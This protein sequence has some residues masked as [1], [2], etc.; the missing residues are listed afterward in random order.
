[1]SVP[2]SKYCGTCGGH[3]GHDLKAEAEHVCPNSGDEPEW[4]HDCGAELMETGSCDNDHSEDEDPEPACPHQGYSIDSCRD[5]STPIAFCKHCGV[6]P[7][8]C[9]GRQNA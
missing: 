7:H 3:Y 1:M 9:E 6:L 2:D 5:C 8:E 4:C